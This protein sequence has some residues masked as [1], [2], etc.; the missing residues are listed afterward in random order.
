MFWKLCEMKVVVFCLVFLV[1]G[2]ALLCYEVVCTYGNMNGVLGRCKVFFWVG[3]RRLVCQVVGL[4][5]FVLVGI[6]FLSDVVIMVV[7]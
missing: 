5:L 7:F 3:T 4:V 2:D 6:F 1:L